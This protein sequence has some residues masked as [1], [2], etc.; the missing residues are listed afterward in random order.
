MHVNLKMLFSAYGIDSHPLRCPSSLDSVL[1]ILPNSHHNALRRSMLNFQDCLDEDGGLSHI[2]STA[3]T[4]NHVPSADMK[5][6]MIELRLAEI[7]AIEMSLGSILQRSWVR[8]KDWRCE[9]SELLSK[10]PA[11]ENRGGLEEVPPLPSDMS[12]FVW[13]MAPKEP[14]AWH[15]ECIKDKFGDL[16]VPELSRGRK[17]YRPRRSPLPTWQQH[18]GDEVSARYVESLFLFNLGQCKEI[19]GSR[20]LS[21][22]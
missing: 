20:L 7:W 21:V 10:C 13:R 18:Q 16:W 22:Y 14:S 17:K 11:N 9:I 2:S 19:E 4:V 1:V 6:R 8:T 12:S 3:Q 5:S 15:E